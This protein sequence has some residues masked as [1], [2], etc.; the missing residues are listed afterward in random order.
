MFE[1]LKINGDV[2]DDAL[3]LVSEVA[4]LTRG[5]RGTIRSN[6]EKLFFLMVFL[7]R[8]VEV[9]EV[10]VTQNIKTREHV[11]E[12]A[13]TFARLFHLNVVS[14]AVRFYN[15]VDPDALDAAMVVDLRSAKFVTR[16]DPSTRRRCFSVENTLFTP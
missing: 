3:A 10:L 15:E 16:R 6:R 11:L 8:G 7:S 14:G 9:L 1:R 5:R 13:K 12:N 4:T 2:F